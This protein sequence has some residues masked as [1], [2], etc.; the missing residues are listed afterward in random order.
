MIKEVLKK[1]VKVIIS[2]QKA[3]D[4]IWGTHLITIY[5]GV[6]ALIPGIAKFLEYSVVAVVENDIEVFRFIV[7]GSS[8]LSSLLYILLVIATAWIIALLVR[9]FAKPMASESGMNACLCV[10]AYAMTPI[11]ISFILGFIPYIGF[12]FVLYS[13]LILIIGV[14]KILRPKKMA[15]W[16]Y[17][18]SIMFFL[19][20][21]MVT[22]WAYNLM[23]KF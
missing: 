14:Q 17:L 6:L 22:E 18:M 10:V 7:T 16:L 2:P 20:I 23:T 5:I 11:L 21:Q 8:I 9:I 4:K 1:A 13:V 3:M 15:F 12:F 19:F